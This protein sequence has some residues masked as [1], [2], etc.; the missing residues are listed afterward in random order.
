MSEGYRAAVAMLIDL[1]RHLVE[2]YGHEGLV[3]ETD[4]KWICPHSGVVLIDEVDS[5]LH[6][7][8][9]RRIGF[10]LKVRFPEN[11]IYRYHTQ[12]AYLSSR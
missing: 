5:H 8:W 6:P 9:Q 12:P 3:E 10:W 11:P 2:T 1:L 7:E 4:G